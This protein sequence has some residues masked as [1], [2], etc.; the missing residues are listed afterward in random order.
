MRG[1]PNVFTIPPGVPFLETLVKACLNGSLG[2]ALGA[3]PNDLSAATIYVPTRRAAR[4][5][6]HAFT[7]ALKPDALLLPRVVPLGDPADLDESALLGDDLAEVDSTIPPAITAVD[8]QLALARLVEGWRSSRHMAALDA[9]GDGFT[10]GGSF[11]DSFA[12]AGELGRLIDEFSLEGIDWGRI[13]ALAPLE[14]DDYWRLTRDFLAIAGQAWPDY[15][16]E[17]GLLDPAE[18]LNRQLRAAAAR[19]RATPPAGPVIAAGSTGSVP[20]T[21]AL[22]ATIARLPQGAVV[23]PGLDTDMDEQG[24]QLVAEGAAPEPAQ[25]GHPQAALKTLLQRMGIGRESVSTLGATDVG[26]ARIVNASMRA[27]DATEAWPAMRAALAGELPAAL[28]GVSILEARDEREEALSIAVALRGALEQPGETAALI[29]PDRALAARVVAELKRWGLAVD[30]S[31]GQPL[32]LLSAG[33]RARLVLKAAAPEARPVDC[34]ALLHALPNDARALEAVE[35]GGLRDHDIANGPDGWAAAMNEAE[36]RRDAPHA[37]KPLKRVTPEAL[38]DARARISGLRAALAPLAA[39]PGTRRPIG[40]WAQAHSAVMAAL[41]Q[42]LADDTPDTSALLRLLDQLVLA[43][44]QPLISA[45][46]YAAVFEQMSAGVA[47]AAGTVSQGRIKIFGLLEAR[48]I[49]A[50][51]VVLGGLNERTWPSD[52]RT[53]PFLNRA[54]RA[55]LGLSSPERRIGQSAHDFAQGLG[56]RKVLL[57]RA[58]TVE[59]TPMVASRFMRRLN[60]FIGEDAAKALR[61]RANWLIEA[62]QALDA[63]PPVAPAMRPAPKPPRAVQPPSLSITE[64]ATLYRDPYAIYARHILD[65]APLPPLDAEPD[66]RDKGTLIHEALALFVAEATQAW[67]ADPLARLLEI[68]A[69]VFEPLMGRERTAAFWWPVFTRM[70]ES[71]IADEQERRGAT[72]RSIVETRATLPLVL[73]DGT[74]FTLRG[75]PDRI[76]VLADGSL[77]ILDYKTG[78]P[79]SGP[80]VFF[81]LEP[82]LTLAAAMALKGAFA[83]L[84]ATDIKEIS[85]VRVGA[86]YERKAVSFAKTPGKEQGVNAIALGH[87]A[88]LTTAL[89]RLRAGTDAYVA[90]RMPGKTKDTGDYDHLARTTEWMSQQD[91]E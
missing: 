91:P 54:M 57:T 63:A 22:L 60:T 26:R 83:G 53:D 19:L 75:K 11:A 67:P 15:L 44:T 85:Y 52:A 13:N 86:E 90:R 16:A 50:T 78:A 64:I 14:H 59:G 61:T 45:A 20:A 66:A 43:S 31:A 3:D 51:F 87:L 58:A 33:H 18:R 74:V 88:S 49:P 37:P 46:D 24:W 39:E 42:A 84:D 30:D 4:A 5:L 69:A 27:A 8:R 80:Q 82:Q 81:N 34:L 32:A 21:A 89:N 9:A 70:A 47:V 73:E 56:A 62:A 55:V 71:F 1:L 38:Q 79:P 28:E 23:L 36:K 35:L 12:L 65:L 17:L 10:L 68:G 40:D 25:P 72:L 29:T 48:L 76:D 6:I 77:A 2:F 41:T 7:D